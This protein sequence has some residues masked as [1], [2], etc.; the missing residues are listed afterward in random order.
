MKDIKTRTVVKEIK[1]LDRLPNLM[2]HVKHASDR[3]KQHKDKDKTTSQSPIEYAQ[4]HSESAIDKT[5]R[6]QIGVSVV[7]GKRL[8]TLIQ[9]KRAMSE[10]NTVARQNPAVI[11]SKPSGTRQLELVHNL[12]LRKPVDGKYL[13]SSNHQSGKQR[14]IR[15]RANA[16]LQHP[17]RKDSVPHGILHRGS[18]H[19]EPARK[20]GA[21]TAAAAHSANVRGNRSKALM[22]ETLGERHIMQPSSRVTYAVSKRAN[23]TIK[24]KER[25]FKTLSPF[26]KTGQRLGQAKSRSDHQAEG[27]MNSARTAQRAAQ[28][29]INTHRSL[30]RA[31]ATARLNLRIIKMVVKAAALLV[32][33]AAALLGISST[34]IVLLCIV[35]AVAAVIAS[36]FSIFVSGENTDADVKPLSRIVQ[37]LDAEFADRLAEIQQSAGHVDRVEIHYPGSA[38]N[39]RIDNWMDVIAVFAVKTVMDS[40]NGMDVAT[41]DATRIRINHSVFW[42]MNQ[43][44]SR[45]E[46]IEHTETVTVENEDGSTS[47]ET[48][49]SYEY[50]L[51]ITVTSKTAEQ[52]A[53]S[54]HFTNEQMDI[55]KEMMSGEFRPLMLA[56]LGK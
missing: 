37:E 50:V 44:E 4:H 33:G 26:I 28:M 23:Y 54:Y 12:H 11:I 8:I 29:A 35:M 47:E 52:Q 42:D 30:Q 16:R 3:T 55:M 19:Q 14:F 25:K 13:F 24:R 32:K 56:M 45:V 20:K 48:T 38:D 31:Q 21:S 6:A 53:D 40:E 34:V 15:G 10:D 27:K 18:R 41:L 36:P 2:D 5:V 51:H 39:T 46:T 43:I 1:R 22:V 9:K 7:I 49:T 17:S